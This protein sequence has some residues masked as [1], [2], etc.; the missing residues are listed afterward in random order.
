MLYLEWVNFW[1]NFLLQFHFHSLNHFSL[2]NARRN[3]L[4]LAF[5]I[6]YVHIHYVI[7]KEKNKELYHIS[8]I[9][10]WSTNELSNYHL[11][12]HLSFL[13]WC[14]PS[15]CFRLH[16]ISSGSCIYMNIHILVRSHNCMSFITIFLILAGTQSRNT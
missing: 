13:Y 5:C 7:K 16:G 4:I 11:V 14:R 1:C 9:I 3:R 8:G 15:P 2:R 6:C 12:T 10:L